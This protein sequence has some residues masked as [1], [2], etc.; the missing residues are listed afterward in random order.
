M[1]GVDMEDMDSPGTFF[2]DSGGPT[3]RGGILPSNFAD[4]GNERALRLS[5]M[6]ATGC[7]WWRSNV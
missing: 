2:H 5:A 6:R 1:R 3:I 4:C 7:E